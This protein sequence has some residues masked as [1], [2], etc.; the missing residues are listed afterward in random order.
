MPTLYLVRHGETDFNV[1]GRLQGRFETSLNARGRRQATACA[2]VLRDLFGRDGKAAADFS[3]V[4]SPLKRARETM[5]L[6]RAGLGLD[7][8]G[9]AVDA[10]LAEI[11]YGD[12]EGRTLAEI[13]AADPAVLALRDRDKWDFAPPRS[14]EHTSDSSHSIASRMPSSA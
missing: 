12:W 8:Q 10:R 4:S 7:A 11:S 6:V 3:Y 9:Y 2:G 5:E 14:E 13:G 1:E